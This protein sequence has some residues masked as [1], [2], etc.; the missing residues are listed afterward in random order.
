[1]AIL[2]AVGGGSFVLVSIIVGARLLALARSN[3]QLPE[4]A[5]GM[6]LFLMAGVGYPL[7]ILARFGAFLPEPTRLSLLVAYQIAQIVG[8]SALC[9]FN[10]HTFRRNSGPAL[11]LM[12]LTS[13]AMIACFIAQI[14]GPGLRA[15]MYDHV[16]PWSRTSPLTMIPLAWASFESLR[17]YS[18]MKKRAR[19]G[20]ANPA[21]ADRFGLWSISA[22][23]AAIMS[24]YS[25]LGQLNGVDVNTTVQGPIVLGLLGVTAAGSLWLAFLPPRWFIAWREESEAH[26]S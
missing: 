16:G 18:M 21:V 5:M 7:M 3:R 9:V 4:F 19:I 11:V 26:A 10:W 22:L 20:M 15:F 1:M 14:Q 24:G 12:L 8:I 23:G 2:G 25:Y 17:Y 13:G 6:G